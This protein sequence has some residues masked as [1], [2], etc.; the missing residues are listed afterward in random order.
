MKA[1]VGLPKDGAEGA[2]LRV[3][4][5]PTSAATE[6]AFGLDSPAVVRLL[7]FDLLGRE[8]AVVAGAQYGPGRHTVRF[9]AA[10]LSAGTYLCR[11]EADGVTV[12]DT[13]VTIVH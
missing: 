2:L 8:A 13:A 6:I 3:Y 7:L 9:N 5:N 4:P 1:G 11:L 10:N 12:A